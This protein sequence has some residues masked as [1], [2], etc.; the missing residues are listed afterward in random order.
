MSTVPPTVLDRPPSGPALSPGA[1]KKS[2]AAAKTSVEKAA[3]RAK[4]EAR[5]AL[6][7][8]IHVLRFSETTGK[9][10]I[11]EEE[12]AIL[13]AHIRKFASETEEM[14]EEIEKNF[15]EI[16]SSGKE[17]TNPKYVQNN[18][19]IETL[20]MRLKKLYEMI[21]KTAQI[22]SSFNA[23]HPDP[24]ITRCWKSVYISFSDLWKKCRDF[25]NLD[26]VDLLIGCALVG[27]A[28]AALAPYC[29]SP[30]AVACAESDC[31]CKVVSVAGSLLFNAPCCLDTLCRMSNTTLVGGVREAEVRLTEAPRP[32]MMPDSELATIGKELTTINQTLKS[33]TVKIIQQ[34]QGRIKELIGQLNLKL[35]EVQKQLNGETIA[36][37]IETPDDFSTEGIQKQIEEN[38]NKLITIL[39]KLNDALYLLE[40]Y[41]QKIN[42]TD[43]SNPAPEGGEAPVS[44]VKIP[45]YKAKELCALKEITQDAQRA[46]EFLQNRINRK[47]CSNVEYKK[48]LFSLCASLGALFLPVIPSLPLLAETVAIGALGSLVARKTS[49]LERI[50]SMLK[51]KRD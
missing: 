27:G 32:Q 26:D 48:A 9:K 7:L 18:I 2:D 35:A 43:S 44:A 15:G 40:I 50:K 30:E 29:L 13:L 23:K 1:V 21:Q 16:F 6:E 47:E 45:P 33:A 38:I 24:E 37:K 34:Q 8:N 36:Q 22:V 19:K 39:N 3:T 14:R 28:T 25:L 10:F 31:A 46:L 41:R 11:T 17:E 20:K 49:L 42:A 5:R 4:D 51:L 12:I